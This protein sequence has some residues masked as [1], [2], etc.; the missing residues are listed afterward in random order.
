VTDVVI[1]QDP[2]FGG[3]AA[4]QMSM[5]VDAARALGHD[6][7]LVY[8]AHPSLVGTHAGT[9]PPFGHVDAL[10]QLWG[11]RRLAV[12]ARRG[13]SL[14]VVATTAQYGAAAPRSR[15]DYA[16]WIGTSLASENTGRSRGLR[17]SRRV[18]MH[19]NAPVLSRLERAVLRGAAHVYATSPASRDAVAEA[20]GLDVSHVGILPL[21]VDVDALSPV[22]DDEYLARLEAPVL[23]FAG[24][25]GDLRKN[26]R[27]AQDAVA[28]VPGAT[29]R[30]TGPGAPGSIAAALRDASLLL[31]PSYQEGFG[32]VAAEAL[33]AG[34][35]VVATPSGGPE[36]LIRDSGGGTV[37]AGWSAE[38]FAEAIQRLLGEGDALVERRRRAR[39]YV[40]REHAPPALVRALREAWAND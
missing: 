37:T 27:L 2:R 32:I 31:L 40:L 23:V 36:A 6:P 39:E 8:L 14:W 16:C 20:G 3:G 13:T 34:V 11:A 10:N 7:E 24:R 33:A 1:G 30:V 25:A 19:V 38:E 12:T 18:A 4:A 22:P 35:P 9:P 5:F 15:R 26:L 21:I 29:L 28:L 17:L